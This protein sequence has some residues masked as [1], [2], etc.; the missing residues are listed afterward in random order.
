MALFSFA[1]GLSISL[2]PYDRRRRNMLRSELP[3]S[4]SR[5]KAAMISIP[6]V[7]SLKKGGSCGAPA[8]GWGWGTFSKNGR[9]SNT[10][11]ASRNLAGPQNVSWGV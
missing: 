3:V 1:F 2:S 11:P 4:T 5:R 7:V 9:D 6:C 8:G 10:R